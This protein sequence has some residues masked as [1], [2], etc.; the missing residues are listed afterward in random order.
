MDQSVDVTQ[1]KYRILWIW[2]SASFILKKWKSN[3]SNVCKYRMS[4]TDALQC[5]TLTFQNWYYSVQIYFSCWNKTEIYSYFP[6][7]QFH[8]PF[9]SSAGIGFFFFCSFNHF[10]I[11]NIN[12]H[13]Y[14]ETRAHLQC[15]K[16]RL[17]SELR[18]F[19][20]SR[21]S[22][23]SPAATVINSIYGR[24]N[25]AWNPPQDW[26]QTRSVTLSVCADQ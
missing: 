15:G 10:N 18:H 9:L 17:H 21:P 7:I 19:L 5:S 11:I 4:W 3:T 14:A 23:H 25:V 22:T 1:G 13:C 26:T 24:E 8:L 12:L 2:K 20:S 16:Y 6:L